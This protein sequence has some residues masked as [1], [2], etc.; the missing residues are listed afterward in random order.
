MFVDADHGRL[1]QKALTYS[2]KNR[3]N[4]IFLEGFTDVLENAAYWRSTD[5]V[6]YD[7][8]NQRLNILPVSYT[9]LDVYKRQ[10]L[11]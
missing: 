3:A 9:H 6:Y 10:A 11:L 7:Y 5:E 1:L 2:V 8:P 4:L